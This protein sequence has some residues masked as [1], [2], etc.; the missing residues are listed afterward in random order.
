MTAGCFASVLSFQTSLFEL[1]TS[2]VVALGI[3]LSATRL[4][5]V[6]G[7]PALDYPVVSIQVGHLRVELRTSCSQSRRASICTCIR[8]C[9]VFAADVSIGA[10]LPCQWAGRH[11]N[12]RLRFFRPPLDR[13]SYQPMLGCSGVAR[14]GH[15]KRLDACVTPSLHVESSSLKA[16][17]T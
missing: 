16:S 17:V 13:L 1:Q 7:Q 4:S 6:S 12:P 9:V 10:Y 15:E 2:K 11:S 14:I 3:E 8:C 5:A